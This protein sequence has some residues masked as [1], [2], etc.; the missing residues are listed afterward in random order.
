ML[1]VFSL[2]MNQIYYYY[3]IL[4]LQKKSSVHFKKTSYILKHNV[5]Y[6]EACLYVAV[7]IGMYIMRLNWRNCCVVFSE[8]S[9]IMYKCA[10][11]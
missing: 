5:T 10:P 7:W 8:R 11:L 4:Y 2:A 3:Y 9:E 6:S 1:L